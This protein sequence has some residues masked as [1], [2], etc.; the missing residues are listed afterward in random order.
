[1]HLTL[2]DQIIYINKHG[3]SFS[4]FTIIFGVKIVPNS[5]SHISVMIII[6]SLTYVKKASIPNSLR[7]SFP[8]TCPP[9]SPT[10]PQMSN[11]LEMTEILGYKTGT[12]TFI[13]GEKARR[14]AQLRGVYH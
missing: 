6:V 14:R 11:E 2:Y 12:M 9:T 7:S 5:V 8:Q 10:R 3:V 1:M 13:L 4:V